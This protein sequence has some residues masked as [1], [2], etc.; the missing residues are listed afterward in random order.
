MNSSSPNNELPK[1][2]SES[3]MAELEGYL[4]SEL[5]REFKL[6]NNELLGMI[7]R[8]DYE[9]VTR[10]R[11]ELFDRLSQFEALSD[12][13]KQKTTR[14]LRDSRQSYGRVV[15]QQRFVDELQHP[16]PTPP[17]PS[18][19]FPLGKPPHSDRR[20]VP[21]PSNDSAPPVDEP[22]I[23]PAP[24]VESIVPDSPAPEPVPVEDLSHIATQAPSKDY[25]AT[26][27]PNIDNIL[28]SA[29]LTLAQE[30]KVIQSNIEE[31]APL[32]DDLPAPVSPLKK[33]D[34]HSLDDPPVPDVAV[35]E[36][37]KKV[38]SSTQKKGSEEYYQDRAKRIRD[39]IHKD[40][41]AGRVDLK[42]ES[43]LGDDD[44]L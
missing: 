33:T 1:G 31:E 12:Q 43:P 44:E 4:P 39:Y 2:I 10:V 32:L 23:A 19:A 14:M 7:D 8:K 34:H 11:N 20:P 15:Q 29:P 41:R 22:P 25:D 28:K 18:D 37:P 42:E 6:L 27:P 16:A 3:E 5:L 36:A 9:G 40:Q 35:E 30:M 21:K 38:R 13:L 24:P 17:L 26:P